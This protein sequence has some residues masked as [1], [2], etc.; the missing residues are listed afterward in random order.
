[1]F[2]YPER[3]TKTPLFSPLT[4]V[5]YRPTSLF[6]VL[7]RKAMGRVVDPQSTS[8]MLNPM[9]GST[10]LPALQGG[11]KCY[12]GCNVVAGIGR[13]SPCSEVYPESRACISNAGRLSSKVALIEVSGPVRQWL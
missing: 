4:G 9:P 5:N 11:A 1:M 7:A 10:L 6:S 13:S 8:V 3:L 12:H 2:H